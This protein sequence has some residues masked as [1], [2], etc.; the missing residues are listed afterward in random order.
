MSV[1]MEAT[2]LWGSLRDAL[3]GVAEQGLG[4]WTWLKEKKPRAGW[5]SRFPSKPS[6]TASSTEW[7]ASPTSFSDQVWRSSC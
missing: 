5:R 2:Q 6:R 7:E 4:L 3:S 1:G